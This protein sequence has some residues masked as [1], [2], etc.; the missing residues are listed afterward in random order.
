MTTFS[1]TLDDLSRRSLRSWL[2]LALRFRES[3]IVPYRN[4]FLNLHR[5]CSTRGPGRLLLGLQ[6][7]GGRHHSSQLVMRRGSALEVRGDFSIYSGHDIW[8]NEGAVLVLGSGYINNHLNLSCFEHIEIGDG[9]A[10]SEHVTIRDSDN[11]R[12][13]AHSPT[14]PVRIGNKVWIG[15][16]ATILAGVTV[17]DGAMVAAGAVVTRDVPPRALVAGVPAVIKKTDVHWT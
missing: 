7:E 17:G 4:T 6:W 11:V 1:E 14:R 10:I 13:G 9:V 12:T 8:I 5:S 16:N 15:L 3:R 2:Y